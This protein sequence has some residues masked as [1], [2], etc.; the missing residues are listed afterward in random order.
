MMKLIPFIVI[1][2]SSLL[3]EY[4]V[5]QLQLINNENKVLRDFQS[6]L[7]PLQYPSYFPL[8]PGI[9][10]QYTKTWMCPENTSNFKPICPDP[11]SS[12]LNSPELNKVARPTEQ[13][14]PPPINPIANPN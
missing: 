6:T 11:K 4:R 14:L 12:T 9:K 5:F 8:S 7:D 10:I 1:I 3:A 13:S 2:P